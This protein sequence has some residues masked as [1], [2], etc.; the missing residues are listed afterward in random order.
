[1]F[2]NI[3]IISGII[4]VFGVETILIYTAL[5]LKKKIA[6]YFPPHSIQDLLQFTRQVT[7][8]NQKISSFFQFH[9]WVCL[10]FHYRKRTIQ[11][12]F[13]VQKMAWQGFTISLRK[14]SDKIELIYF[15]EMKQS[16]FYQMCWKQHFNQCKAQVKMLKFSTHSIK[17]FW[18]LPKKRENF[19]L[20]FLGELS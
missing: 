4:E 9:I 10:Y 5:L 3:I 15:F 11:K 18:Y 12:Y 2:C 8:G 19:L 20:Y 7:L 16:I 6:V 14:K 17:Y 1:M 13:I